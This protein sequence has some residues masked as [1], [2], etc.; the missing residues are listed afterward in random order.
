MRTMRA[1]KL[2]RLRDKYFT[3]LS[4][5]VIGREAGLSRATV[6]RI[7][8]EEKA[9][10]RLADVPRPRFLDRVKRDEPAE[11]TIAAGDDAPGID[12]DA[13]PIGQPNRV[14]KAEC[15]AL[16]DA[17]RRHHSDLDGAAPQTAPES[18]LRFDRKGMPT[19]THGMLMA[20]CRAEDAAT[21]VALALPLV[22]A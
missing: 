3:D 11:P 13:E 10:G 6:Q 12:A 5:E 7:W 16:L 21:R 15:G 18:W 8:A 22:P 17:L 9:A 2:K 19:P 1:G 20:M 4:A 14:C